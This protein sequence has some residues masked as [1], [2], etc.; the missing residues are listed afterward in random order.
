MGLMEEKDKSLS[1]LGCG[2]GK[3][4]MAWMLQC[5]DAMWFGVYPRA[6]SSGPSAPEYRQVIQ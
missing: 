6:R 3:S 5:F 2:F 1:R 4:S